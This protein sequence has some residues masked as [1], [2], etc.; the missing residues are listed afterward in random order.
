MSAPPAPVAAPLRRLLPLILFLAMAGP[1]TLNILQPSMPGL[2][3]AL[4]APREI[5]QLTLTLYVLGMALAQLIAGPL[6][7]RFGR[8]P[9]L[10]VALSLF[11]LASLAGMNATGIG[12]LIASRIVQ[13]M[14]ATACLGLSRAIISDLSDRATT[15]RMIAYVTMVMV[16][17]PMASPNIG[18]FLDTHF[19]WRSIFLFC[20]FFG[21]SLVLSVVLVLPE[22]RPAT[23]TAATFADVAHRSMGLI[24][25]RQFTRYAFLAGLASCCFFAMLGATPSLVIEKMGRSPAEYGYWFALLGI[26]YSLGNFT[27]GRFTPVVGLER[28]AAAGNLVQLVGVVIMAGL[29]LVPVMHP[30][31]LF[32]PGVLVTYGNGLVLPNVMASGIQT[33]RNAAG[34]ASGLIGFSQMIMSAG[35]SYIVAWLPGENA[36]A[37]TVLMLL[38]SGLAQAMLPFRFT[39]K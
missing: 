28:M 5:V 24:R 32:V 30:A 37:L 25:N 7:D 9:V 29:A 3:K 13:A 27:T 2:E 39:T 11:I 22:T 21:G 8:R 38:F 18:S 34:A 26:G 12:M 20:I 35:A 17:A 31:A 4:G 15:A 1:L 33:D 23:I 19:G 36:L 14:G 10:I 16:L 6:A